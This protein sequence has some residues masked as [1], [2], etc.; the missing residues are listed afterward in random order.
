ME[1]LDRLLIVAEVFLAANK[2]DGEALAKVQHFRYPLDCCIHPSAS[3]VPC[4]LSSQTKWSLRTFSCTLSKESG[5]ST[6]KQMRM[7]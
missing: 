3:S 5:E 4:L 6:A 2:D 1:F 7:T